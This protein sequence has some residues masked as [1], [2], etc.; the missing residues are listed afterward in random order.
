MS[1]MR[2]PM[3]TTAVVA[4]SGLGLVACGG[5]GDTKTVTVQ[6]PTERFTP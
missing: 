3:I 2:L 1:R 4:L 6:A 5:G